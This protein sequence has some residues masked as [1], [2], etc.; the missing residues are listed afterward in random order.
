MTRKELEALSLIKKQPVKGQV[1]CCLVGCNNNAWQGIS[2]YC[3]VHV[4]GTDEQL[5]PC[6]NCHLSPSQCQGL[7]SEDKC[8]F[9]E[10]DKWPVQKEFCCDE[11]MGMKAELDACKQ[12]LQKHGIHMVSKHCWCNPTVENDCCAEPER[13]QINS[14]YSG[15]CNEGVKC[16]IIAHGVA[17]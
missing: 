2:D 11:A 4:V 15:V 10:T 5:E 16:C 3:E 12:L 13:H 6:E 8:R 17:E 9:K 7:T 14:Q 1:K